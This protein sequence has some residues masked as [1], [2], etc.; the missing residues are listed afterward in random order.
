MNRAAVIE[1]LQRLGLRLQ[2]AAAVHPDESDPYYILTAQGERDMAFA[3]VLDYDAEMV[4]EDDAYAGWVRLWAR[5]TGREHGLAD[6]ASHVDFDGGTS[7][8]AYRLD[9]AAVR[10]EFVQDGD[11]LD[12][13]VAERIIEDF[14]DVP[15]RVRLYVDNGQGGTYAWLPEESIA[16]FRALFPEAERA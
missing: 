3:H 4:E 15:G 8:L 10:M 1:A 5:V 14:G 12:P 9:G 7:W 6:V 2:D 13:D 16:G 11:W